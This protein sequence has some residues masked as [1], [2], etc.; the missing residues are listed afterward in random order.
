[1]AR[2]KVGLVAIGGVRVHNQKLAEHGVSLPG[3]VDRGKVIASLPSLAM[4]I[5]AA[6]TP[7]DLE[8]DL[9][10]ME[11]NE[12]DTEGLGQIDSSDFQA[13][14]ISTY[15]AK[16]D[17]A[18]EVA[19][20]FRERGVTVF[21]GGLH[22]TLVGAE[23]PLEH[24]DA[25]ALGEGEELWPRMLRDWKDGK[26]Q[27][28]YREEQPGTYDL[29]KTPVP[30]FD[31]LDLAAFNRITVQTSR[32]CPHDCEF[33][34]ASKVFGPYR[35]KPV[36]QVIAELQ[37][38]KKH[39]EN[40][41]IEL[42]DDNTFVNRRW[43]QELLEAMKPLGLHWFTETDISLADN[44]EALKVLYDSGCRQVLIGLES[45]RAEGLKGI[46]ARNW[47]LKQLDRYREAI[48]RIQRSGVTV[49]GTFIVGLDSDTP[50]SF[51]EIV[52]F[53]RS[54]D[55]CEVQITVSTPFPGT[56]LFDRLKA[57]GRLLRDRFYEQCTL[58][59]VTYEPKNMSVA[60]LE[61]GLL[62]MFDELYNEKELQRRK[63]IYVDLVKDL[64]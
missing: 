14:A 48:E 35:V 32:G 36:A 13:V 30:R 57:E 17:V 50:D 28:V 8:I 45:T 53:V 25:V 39:W 52:D 6:V 21:F 56:R 20:R 41:F 5:L 62:W 63:R 54:S 31:L 3:F 42:A 33:C 16:V 46:D 27:R 64:L 23:E 12:C 49:N 59:D 15:T 2:R 19:D 26:L 55:L 1:M 47:K 7:E 51:Q 9:E 58:F 37:E 11:I 44:P 29:A 22:A 4:L 38:I 43:S 61:Q 34:G 60:E 18:Y 10:Y 40:P 24:A